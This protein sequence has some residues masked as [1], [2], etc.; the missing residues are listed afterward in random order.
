MTPSLTP[1]VLFC[2]VHDHIP[3]FAH[4]CITKNEMQIR[5]YIL[6]T[7]VFVLS[8]V[9]HILNLVTQDGI[10]WY[11][12]SSAVEG[13]YSVSLA[14]ISFGQPSKQ[15]CPHT[16]CDSSSLPVTLTTAVQGSG[17]LPAPSQP[18]TKLSSAGVFLLLQ[19]KWL[20]HHLRSPHCSTGFLQVAG[21]SGRVGVSAEH[22]ACG[23]ERG[24]GR[25]GFQRDT[26]SEVGL[27]HLPRVFCSVLMRQQCS[28]LP[29][30]HESGLAA[31]TQVSPPDRASTRLE[32]TPGTTAGRHS[33]FQRLNVIIATQAAHPPLKH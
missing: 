24:E 2:A 4:Q 10:C 31:N 5:K 22:A 32:H 7:K 12:P 30:T 25:K 8:L 28:H 1:E 18:E 3:H 23:R 6:N 20:L 16:P 21:V 33:L 9:H 19:S 17:P 14:S 13:S 15:C 27:G 29:I 11:T 26:H